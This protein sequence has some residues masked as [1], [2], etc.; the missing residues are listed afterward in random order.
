I[1]AYGNEASRSWIAA[2]AA[3]SPASD[4]AIRTR[5]APASVLAVSSN[6]ASSAGGDLDGDG[7]AVG[8]H[9]VDG[10]ARLG[11]L[12]D[13]AQLLLRRVAGHPE[14]D[15]DLLE[16]VARLVVDAERAAH[17]H[18]TGQR[19]LDRGQL[20]LPSGGDVDD[21]RRQAGRKRVQQVLG[22]VGAGVGAEQDRRLARVELPALAAAGVLAPGGVETL[23]RRA[24]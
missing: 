13:L 15:A 17:V 9:V 4:S 24:G 3:K 1:P 14:R 2:R 21:R 6:M 10:R 5:R 8:D 22:G 11:P 23:D 19:R 18:V 20:H 12:D 7:H 16:A